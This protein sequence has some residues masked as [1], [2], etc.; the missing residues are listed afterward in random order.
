MQVTK[1]DTDPASAAAK[2]GSAAP[3]K[4]T[5]PPPSTHDPKTGPWV[6][7]WQDKPQH[8]GVPPAAKSNVDLAAANIQRHSASPHSKPPTELATAR[9][10]AVSS[11]HVTDNLPVHGA[12][13]RDMQ[14]SDGTAARIGGIGS[15]AESSAAAVSPVR[16]FARSSSDG[17]AAAGVVAAK[18]SFEPVTAPPEETL[19]WNKRHSS[20]KAAASTITAVSGAPKPTSVPVSAGNAGASAGAGAGAGADSSAAPAKPA[21]KQAAYNM[22]SPSKGTLQVLRKPL[23]KEP[24]PRKQVPLQH[25]LARQAVQGQPHAQ[26]RLNSSEDPQ[27]QQQQH[28]Q[29]AGTAAEPTASAAAAEQPVSR[30]VLPHAVQLP[31][32]SHQHAELQGL[33]LSQIDASVFAALPAEHQQELLHNLPKATNRPSGAAPVESKQMGAS[34]FAFITKLANL[35]KGGQLRPSSA[36]DTNSS[37]AAEN[38]PRASPQVAIAAAEGTD[39]PLDRSRGEGVIS[40]MKATSLGPLKQP[41]ATALPPSVIVLPAPDQEAERPE[42]G[43]DAPVSSPGD[44]AFV[45]QL[46]ADSSAGHAACHA[47]PSVV[48]KGIMMLDEQP[49]AYHDH[50]DTGKPAISAQQAQHV[51]QAQ[52][53]R[54]AQHAWQAPQPA[55]PIKP[56]TG[57]A[58]NDEDDDMDQALDMDLMEEEWVALAAHA[59]RAESNKL[60]QPLAQPTT[61]DSAPFQHAH[62]S[63]AQRGSEAAHSVA[64]PK[65]TGQLNASSAAGPVQQQM[66]ERRAAGMQQQLVS[67]L[68]PAS[69]IDSSVLD[70]LPLQVRRELELA[71]GISTSS[72]C[73]VHPVCAQQEHQLCAYQI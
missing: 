66:Q 28:P 16:A 13:S 4:V 9:H 49:T 32:H 71:Y 2:P 54:Q 51:Q 45:S 22:Y 18:Q 67:A 31:A 25:L 14:A 20:L 39:T 34:D 72:C 62:H 63:L 10:N 8:W 21:S 30:V 43:E 55:A 11:S 40:D 26:G 1:L 38:R 15:A 29:Q 65:H 68:P 73:C 23:S 17:Q 59:Q 35:Q 48:D 57:A 70:A 42:E 69:Q 64:P 5:A 27:Q 50:S 61:A 36:L 52:H 24:S 56:A 53:A 46:S 44:P 19:A 33:T 47:S 12:G 3:A 6:R 41:D 37:K 58:G 60:A 7:F